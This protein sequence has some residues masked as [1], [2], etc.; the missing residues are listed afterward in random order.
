MNLFFDI[1]QLIYLADL[2]H[3]INVLLRESLDFVGPATE[4]LRHR[5]S[6]FSVVWLLNV[7][8]YGARRRQRVEGSKSSS[9]LVT[10]PWVRATFL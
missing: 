9:V 7:I 6:S 5:D 4:I 1:D 3:N 2:A 8:R 10:R